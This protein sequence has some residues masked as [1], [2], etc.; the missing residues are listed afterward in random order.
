MLFML[1]FKTVIF[2]RQ[3]SEDL[4]S[5]ELRKSSVIAVITQ[6]LLFLSVM[7]C[8]SLNRTQ[9]NPLYLSEI[10]SR[11]MPASPVIPKNSLPDLVSNPGW[12]ES[13]AGQA[14]KHCGLLLVV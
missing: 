14:S 6:A 11:S 8:Y 3:K 5:D 2:G 13:L 1:R 9:A 10:S 12:Q 7:A 4:D